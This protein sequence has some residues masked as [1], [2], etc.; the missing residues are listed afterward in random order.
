MAELLTKPYEPASFVHGSSGLRTGFPKR[1][2]WVARRIR[3]SQSAVIVVHPVLFPLDESRYFVPAFP[4][5]LCFAAALLARARCI[6]LN[7]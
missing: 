6:G 5:A 1:Q 3:I 4:F 7:L 2:F